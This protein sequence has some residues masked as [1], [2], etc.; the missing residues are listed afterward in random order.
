MC[1]FSVGKCQALWNEH[2][3][4]KI[5]DFSTIFIDANLFFPLSLFLWNFSYAIFISLRITF[6]IFLCMCVCV[7]KNGEKCNDSIEIPAKYK[8]RQKENPH[9]LG[10][11]I[12]R[13]TQIKKN[14][15]TLCRGF[16][17]SNQTNFANEKKNTKRKFESRASENES[18]IFVLAICDQMNHCRACVRIHKTG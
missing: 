12:Q 2:S 11:F 10:W 1:S 4:F 13:K 9:S 7:C 15:Y 14:V 18:E 16:Y 3:Y 6:D 5:M 8:K 17:E